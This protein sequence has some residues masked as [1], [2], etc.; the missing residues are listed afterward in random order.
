ME[1][2][3]YDIMKLDDES[4]DDSLLVMQVPAQVENQ[5]QVQDNVIANDQVENQVEPQGNV[6]ANDP[7]ENEVQPQ[8][9]ENVNVN[10]NGLA[11]EDMGLTTNQ[12]FHGEPSRNNNKEE[13]A[14]S[15]YEWL[16]ELY[17]SIL[18]K[19]VRALWNASVQPK[20]GYEWET[21]KHDVM[22]CFATFPSFCSNNGTQQQHAS[23]SDS[24]RQQQ[25]TT[26]NACSGETP[27]AI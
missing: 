7:V 16:E 19:D 18:W 27:C 23:R 5:V 1:S 6:D 20:L 10:V 2:S 13:L 21:W 3:E 8:E 22:K 26:G 12:Y 25:E 9:N 15:F 11:E 17:R 14:L 24:L 4:S